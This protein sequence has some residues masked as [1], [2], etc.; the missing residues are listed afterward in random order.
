[1]G[2]FGELAP[3]K[4]ATHIEYWGVFAGLDRPDTAAAF[5]SLSSAVDVW[6]KK[7]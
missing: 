6:L 4:T 3:G 7:L 2:T 5:E 1:L